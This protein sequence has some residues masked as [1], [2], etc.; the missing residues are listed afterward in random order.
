M[1]VMF[2]GAHPDDIELGAG[3]ALVKHLR[4]G[5]KV[6][7]VVLSKGERGGDPR[8]REREVREVINY[9]G[10]SNYFL[11]SFPDTRFY[12]KFIEIKDVL[13]DLIE[14]FKPDRI[15]TH[16]L[17]D[18]HQDH[19]TTAEAVRVAGRRVKQI[20]SFWAPQTYNNFHPS[21]FIDISEFIEEKIRILEMF[22]SQSHKDFL[23]KE[24][25]LGIN[26]YYGFM[27]GVDYAEGFE[28]IRFIEE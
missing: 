12:E 3:G 8:E 5:D 17:S 10:I 6:V 24:T 27:N 20:L 25:I 19:R 28:I 4:K 14:R 1:I 2:V 18:S 26:K 13:E 7:Y 9:L 21:Y 15:Y 11:F 16:S 22:K 23:K